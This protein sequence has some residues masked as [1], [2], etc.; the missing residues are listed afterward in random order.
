MDR[1]SDEE[2]TARAGIPGR[3]PMQRRDF[4]KLGISIAG[5]V[6]T[7]GFS[8]IAAGAQ[9][10]ERT[11]GP[12]NATSEAKKIAFYRIGDGEKVLLISGFPQT[13]RSW[14]RLI[15]LLSSKYQLIP[16]DLPSVGDSG[17]PSA[18]ATTENVA[19][20]FHEFVRNLGAPPHVVAHVRTDRQR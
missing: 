13:R 5:A 11:S 17:I 7:G 12:L 15:P 20:V 9:R 8:S 1:G 4:F 18:P 3:D 19:R 2:S 10:S 6:G 14:N 16:A